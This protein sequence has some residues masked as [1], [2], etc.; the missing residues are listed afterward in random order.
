MV[1]AC[2]SVAGGR[3]RPNRV[4]LPTSRFVAARSE[5]VDLL[6]ARAGVDRAL[7][8]WVWS[9]EAVAGEAAPAAFFADETV[10]GHGVIAV[11]RPKMSTA[12][13]WL[14]VIPIPGASL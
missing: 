10:G 11:S 13:D 8:E 12:S 9:F 3:W 5:M 4:R 1:P 2:P 14:S 7:L 6:A